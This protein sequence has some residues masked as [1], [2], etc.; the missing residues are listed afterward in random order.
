MQ[1]LKNFILSHLI[2]S[3]LAFVKC[4]DTYTN[5]NTNTNTNT[6]RDTDTVDCPVQVCSYD[7]PI[8]RYVQFPF[9]LRNE[10]LPMFCGYSG[11]DLLC[12]SSYKLLIDLPNSGVFAV[13]AIDY[14]N[15][16]IWLNDPNNCLPK[17]L[18]SFNL[19]NFDNSPFNLVQELH[20]LYW[21]Y[22]CSIGYTKTLGNVTPVRCLSNLRYDVV[23]SPVEVIT[24]N[25]TSSRCSYLGTIQIPT[26][27]QSDKV[28]SLDLGTGIRLSWAGPE[29]GECYMKGGRCG[30]KS[31]SSLDVGCFNIPHNG[32][33]KKTLVAIALAFTA[34]FVFFTCCITYLT[35]RAICSRRR[36]LNL[37]NIALATPTT[38]QPHTVVVNGLD[39]ST[40]ESYPK[41]VLGESRRLPKADDK[42]CPICL[43]EYL[44][45][46]T[47]R[48]LPH[49]GHCFH[50]EC[51]DEWL[52]LNASCPVCR[53]TPPNNSGIT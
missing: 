43:G 49:C 2:L 18:L 19:S 51:V 6:Y 20:Q 35:I 4:L 48:T 30:F 3:L 39:R 52:E 46:E 33:R 7:D 44:A 42:I 14:V 50:A 23:A 40:I 32:L 22:N 13:Q 9:Q 53:N 41:V 47:L 36:R 34:P 25:A 24:I 12:D 38:Q 26:W 1:I 8:S 37:I 45:K 27:S 10:S 11:F 15:Q 21:I 29:C 28:Q 17:T 5:T 31:Y 16:E